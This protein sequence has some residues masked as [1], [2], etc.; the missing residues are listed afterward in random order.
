MGDVRD[1]GNFIAAD[2]HGNI[3]CDQCRARKVGYFCPQMSKISS[4]HL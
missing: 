2:K 4:S 3:Q 1:S